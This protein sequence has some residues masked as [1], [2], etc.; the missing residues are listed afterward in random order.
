MWKNILKAPITI[1]TTRIGLKPIPEDKECCETAKKEWIDYLEGLA[2][3]Q[4]DEAS[5]KEGRIPFFKT[6]RDEILSY[7]CEYFH[8]VLEF[9]VDDRAGQKIIGAQTILDKWNKCEG[10]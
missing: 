10:K 2:Y 6:M 8:E 7:D 3:N 5:A 9:M 1:G 4:H